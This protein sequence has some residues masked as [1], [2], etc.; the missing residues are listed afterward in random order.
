MRSNEEI[1]LVTAAQRL[2]LSW[3]TTHRLVLQGQ[4]RGERRN[5]HWFVVE[6]DVER[7]AEQRTKPKVPEPV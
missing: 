6:A 7:L 5:G 1:D 3:H 2:R 4:L